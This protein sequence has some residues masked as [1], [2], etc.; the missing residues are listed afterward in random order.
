MARAEALVFISPVYFVGSKSLVRV[1]FAMLW[2]MGYEISLRPHGDAEAKR[3]IDAA[4]AVVHRSLTAPAPASDP[5]PRA[6]RS[7]A[8]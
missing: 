2:R 3:M 8:R 7:R 5:P 1:L 4:V 6:A